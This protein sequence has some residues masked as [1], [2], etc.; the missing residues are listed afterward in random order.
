MTLR[1][2]PEYISSLKP[3][4]IFVFGLPNGW[5]DNRLNLCDV[6][7]FGEI[8][9]LFLRKHAVFQCFKSSKYKVSD[10]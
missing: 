8:D 10:Y 3:N 6:F 5:R 4:E 2:T 9:K 1:V 7:G